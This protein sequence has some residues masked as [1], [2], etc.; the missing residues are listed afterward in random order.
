M[1]RAISPRSEP[2]RVDALLGGGLAIALHGLVV[3][4][5]L[6]STPTQAPQPARIIEVGL[7]APSSSASPATPQSTAAPSSNQARAEAK[8][9]EPPRPSPARPERIEP[10][11]SR[12][13]APRPAATAMRPSP[14]EP[15][16]QPAEAAPPTA[17]ASA[18]PASGTQTERMVSEPSA[19]P[20]PGPSVPPDQASAELPT[21]APHVN[22]AYLRNPPP[23]YPPRSRR[24]G[25][26]GRVLLRVHV[27]S[28]GA[29][30]EVRLHESSGH[31]RLD[32]AAEAAVKRWRFVPARRGQEPV[33]A[34]V[35]VPIAFNLRS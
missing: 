3:G 18:A 24:L 30:N 10:A 35:L 15:P 17:T 7:L 32:A 28:K 26:Q 11:P 22:A 33:A 34:W 29:P 8:T 1:P 27:D 21:T 2:Q 25:E 16:P 31:P 19:G 6:H 23:T 20:T 4:F 13:E 9:R 12:T 14:T 5:L